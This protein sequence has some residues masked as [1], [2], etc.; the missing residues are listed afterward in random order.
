MAKSTKQEEYQPIVTITGGKNKYTSFWEFTV[1]ES[2]M[3]TE[4]EPSPKERDKKYFLIRP[5]PPKRL[6]VM[7]YDRT[8]NRTEVPHTQPEM[9]HVYTNRD[10]ARKRLEKEVRKYSRELMEKWG[11][12]LMTHSGLKSLDELTELSET[13]ITES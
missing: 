2:D 1:R 10:S 5:C 11:A 4:E 9:I 3:P 13:W 7:I 8:A 6:I 12:K